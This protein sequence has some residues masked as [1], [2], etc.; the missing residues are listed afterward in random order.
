[1]SSTTLSKTGTG[2]AVDT[3]PKFQLNDGPN[4]GTSAINSRLCV[5]LPDPIS[6]ASDFVTT[7][8]TGLWSVEI[9][10]VTAG[11]IGSIVHS[12]TNIAAVTNVLWVALDPAAFPA[13]GDVYRVTIKD[14]A[15]T[16]C[17][18][19]DFSVFQPNI[20]AGSAGVAAINNAVRRIAGLL[21]YRQQVIYS[22]FVLGIPQTTTITLQD[23]AGAALASYR[24]KLFLN[25]AHAVIAETSAAL[26]SNV[27]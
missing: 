20:G 5:L 14:S 11:V 4:P 23:A 27:L 13:N 19:W 7:P 12:A 10:A 25:D 21:G 6:A 26:D 8:G 17:D 9:R 1:M 24:R 22:D 16:V 15:G 2:F 3:Y 18:E